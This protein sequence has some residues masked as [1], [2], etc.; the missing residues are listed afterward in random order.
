MHRSNDSTQVE[1]FLPIILIALWATKASHATTS[2]HRCIAS[3]KF[4]LAVA[5][6]LT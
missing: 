2:E 1:E 3:N 4:Q 6:I 5:P